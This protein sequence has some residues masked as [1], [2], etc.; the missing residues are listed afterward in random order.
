M[1]RTE[2]AKKASKALIISLLDL[3]LFA[4]PDVLW[5][6]GL[7]PTSETHGRENIAA[8]VLKKVVGEVL[9]SGDEVV[10]VFRRF[11]YILAGVGRKRHFLHQFEVF[12]L[13]A[14][15]INL[16]AIKLC[17]ALGPSTD[18]GMVYRAWM[19]CALFHDLGKPIEKVQEITT[20]LGDAYASL[21]AKVTMQ[22][23]ALLEA[24]VP[25]EEFDDI[26]HTELVGV[27]G[28]GWKSVI[29]KDK[30]G[31][32]SAQLLYARIQKSVVPDELLKKL[33]AAVVC[34]C[35]KP[36]AD[37]GNCSIRF[38]KNPFAYMLFLMDNVQEWEREP[39]GNPEHIGG[40]MVG[41]DRNE[42]PTSLHLT[43]QLNARHEEHEKAEGIVRSAI[44]TLEMLRDDQPAADPMVFRISYV[45]LE[46]DDLG[47][48]TLNF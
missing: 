37:S 14:N 1:Y 48:V 11:D 45:D 6:I 32:L 26:V 16:H 19:L 44:A 38:E 10:D 27:L 33:L 18:L 2:R 31:Y 20:R 22:P 34:H 35:V 39:I 8:Y 47:C 17:S 36:G 4:D 9:V 29:A 42:S 46:S 21:G 43:Y 24:E 25:D 30:H 5:R 15:I 41:F 23:G 7:Y 13:G 28:D 40:E 3:E 12:L